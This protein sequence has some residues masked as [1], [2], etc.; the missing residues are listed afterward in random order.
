[1]SL[2]RLIPLAA[3]V[4]LA[5]ATPASAQRSG[6]G[7]LFHQ[8]NAVFTLRGGYDHASANS[9]LFDDVTQNLTLNRSDF[10]G[11]TFGAEVGI[12]VGRRFEVGADIGYSRSSKGSAF[13]NL[14]DNDNLPIEQLTRFERVP[15][16]GTVRVF[17]TEPGRA[18]G[19]LAW[20]PNKVTPWVGA[21]AGA[22]WYRFEQEG[23]FVDFRDYHVFTS[24]VQTDSWT[25]A[26][27]AM[28]GVDVS[29][30]PALALRGD[31]RYVWAHDKPKSSFSTFDRIDLSGTQASIGLSFRL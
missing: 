20:I 26:A 7:Y 4:T 19:Q 24:S 28:G 18:I 9:D 31:V 22:M 23:D 30:T 13:R 12:P 15:L 10:S 6:N 16:M 5:A 8:P 2:R 27:Q 14:I 25:T 29:L 11:L 3:V 1:M 17:L 21:G